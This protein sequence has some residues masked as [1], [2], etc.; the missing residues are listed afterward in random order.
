MEQHNTGVQYINE[1]NR[2]GRVAQA[3]RQ[4][5]A[6]KHRKLGAPLFH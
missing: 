1:Y 4:Q 5:G 3:S 2:G 6:S